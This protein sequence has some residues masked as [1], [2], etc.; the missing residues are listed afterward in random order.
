MDLSQLIGK[1]IYDDIP[2]D[3]W[4]RVLNENMDYSFQYEAMNDPCFS[5][6]KTVLEIGCGWGANL[7][8]LR[9]KYNIK[10][11]G[12]THSLQQFN[13]LKDENIILAEANT[14]VSKKEYDLVM[15][16]QSIT[17]MEDSALKNHWD[18]TNKFYITDFISS[19]YKY[20]ADWDMRIRTKEQYENMLNE[21]GFEIKRLTVWPYE[22]YFKNAQYWL[23]NINKHNIT[24]GH[25]M[26]MLKRLCEDIL[27]N[28]HKLRDVL[29]CDIYAERITK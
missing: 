1:E 16:V 25:Q 7:R 3:V 9:N 6:V 29:M 24:N 23:D 21:I 17:H 26:I 27:G 19:E 12:L 10:T 11:T 28:M 15:F 2:L 4:I 18:T 5:D 20:Q 22:R 14:F 8:T 13:F